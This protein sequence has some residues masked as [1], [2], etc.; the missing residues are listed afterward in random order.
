MTG[1]MF[2]TMV[3]ALRDRDLT[4]TFFRAN[5]TPQTRI[6]AVPPAIRR[7]LQDQ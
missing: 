1:T 2:T 6:T 7:V 5:L 4:A 3:E